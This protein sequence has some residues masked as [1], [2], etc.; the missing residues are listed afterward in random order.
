MDKLRLYAQHIRDGEYQLF[1][2][3]EGY[4]CDLIE[5]VQGIPM[6][7]NGKTVYQITDWDI[8]SL[9]DKDDK[10]YLGWLDTKKNNIKYHY[11]I[12]TKKRGRPSTLIEGF[13]A[14]SP[15]KS[16]LPK[17]IGS[18]YRIDI[19][20]RTSQVPMKQYVNEIRVNTKEH[21]TFVQQQLDDV[22]KSF[23]K[24]EWHEYIWEDWP[25]PRGQHLKDKLD[26]MDH[27]QHEYNKGTMPSKL[28]GMLCLYYKWYISDWG[29]PMPTGKPP[30][31]T[32]SFRGIIDEEREIK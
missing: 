16:K 3:N 11:F 14:S 1:L 28:S 12:D 22:F 21:Y 24:E 20:R 26:A 8:V 27:F 23:T 9:P 13:E 6:K 29:F 5:I 7:L 25:I 15:A 2:K 17:S 18:E 31:H 10:V 4:D 30:V 32:I 19:S